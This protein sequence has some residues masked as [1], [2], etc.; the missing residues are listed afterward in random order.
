MK[1]L[2]ILFFT[3]PFT[4]FAQKLEYSLETFDSE[5]KDPF[6]VYIFTEIVSTIEG[7]ERNIYENGEKYGYRREGNTLFITKSSV[8]NGELIDEQEKTNFFTMF[9]EEQ[10]LIKVG[11]NH[12][13]IYKESGKIG[14]V[15]I[16]YKGMRIGRK[17]FLFKPKKIVTKMPDIEMETS[18]DGKYLQI[19]HMWPLQ[20]YNI[21]NNNEVLGGL[22]FDENLEKIND[23]PLVIKDKLLKNGRILD[24]GFDPK[25]NY[26][27]LLRAKIEKS[28]KLIGKGKNN[29][30]LVLIKAFN[31]QREIFTLKDEG[32]F[33]YDARINFNSKG[34]VV[35]C[36][37]GN[38]NHENFNLSNLTFFYQLH[39]NGKVEIFKKHYL[40]KPKYES[41]VKNS[42]AHEL[43][44][45]AIRHNIYDILEDQD[46]NFTLI[47]GRQSE[48]YWEGFNV[49]TT[50]DIQLYQYSEN[51]L[52]QWTQT[53][54]SKTTDKR[55]YRHDG[56][57]V[58][59][60]YFP[61]YATILND[62]I[63]VLTLGNSENRN[64][65]LETYR[66]DF[67]K[68]KFNG[69]LDL[70]D[71][72]FEKDSGK[73]Y[74]TRINLANAQG[75]NVMNPLDKLEI[76]LSKNFENGILLQF[77]KNK[78]FAKALLRFE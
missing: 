76:D 3:L 19:L 48:T 58:K 50:H 36:G 74:F 8:E 14:A 57:S 52:L 59:E 16:D 1:M 9:H 45:D 73:S 72:A 11:D 21:I 64:S 17:T 10:D 38:D 66:D 61:F 51:G 18:K 75:I 55:L 35:I 78:E 25:G 60:E 71:F 32:V 43:D 28:S 34:D 40:A 41:K 70:F 29:S 39:P 63:H 47:C 46:G 6:K 22:I 15:S 44:H 26:Y 7:L 5:E 56:G 2:L 27:L 24:R 65:N 53:I 49:I 30:Q 4:L 62:K 54:N 23:V 77:K 69:K 67:Y 68:R 13:L 37:F 31:D 42:N 33:A 20:P 12:L